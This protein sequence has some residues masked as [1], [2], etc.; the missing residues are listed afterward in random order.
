MNLK[1]AIEAIKLRVRVEDLLGC[2]HRDHEHVIPCQFPG[3]ADR[4]KPNLR[5]Y[6]D[7][8]SVYCWGCNTGADPIKL[9]QMLRGIARP[10][11]AIKDL[12]EAYHID[13]D[14]PTQ[15]EQERLDAQARRE[16]VLEIATAFYHR[17]LMDFPAAL[18]YLTKERGFTM[19]TIQSQRL[20]W[21][22][23]KLTAAIGGQ[24]EQLKERGL[25]LQ[26]FIDVGLVV[27]KDAKRYDFFFDRIMFPLISQH[28]VVGL[29]GRS[30]PNSGE[31]K[32]LNLKGPK[33]VK[34]G[35]DLELYNGDATRKG[36]VDVGEGLP[37]TV[38]LI[39]WGI[40]ATGA[41]GTGGVDN[42]A[43]RFKKCRKVRFPWDNDK[44]GQREAVKAASK[45][46]EA[47]EDGQCYIV[48]L[49]QEFN[50]KRVKDVNDFM[51]AGG[52]REDYE[53]LPERSLIQH[54]IELINPAAPA[55]ERKRELAP[56]YRLVVRLSPLEQDE[57]FD[58]MKAHLKVPKK[59]SE[60][61]VKKLQL[62]AER[63]PAQEKGEDDAPASKITFKSRRLIVPA[64]DFAF[65][66][67]ATGNVAVFLSTERTIVD[68]SGSR[69]VET[70]E[71]YLIRVVHEGDL[72]DISTH[73][74]NMMGLTREEAKRIP[75]PAIIS[76]R[77]RPEGRHPHAVERF[78]GKKIREVDAAKLF[79]DIEAVFRRY[80]WLPDPRDFKLLAAWVMMTYVYRLFDAIGYLQLHG[81]RESGKSQIMRLLELLCF[82][83]KKSSDA[84]GPAMFR[85]LEANCRTF[86][87]DEA[88]KLNNPQP[89]T[90]AMDLMLLCN[91][92]YKKGGG[93]ERVEKNAQGNMDTVFFDTYS[94]KVFASIAELNYVL[95]SRCIKIA[96][97]R[98]N[99]E[100]A[101]HLR[102]YAQNS[103]REA[104]VIEDIRD[105]LY[106]WM[107]LHFP[108]VH[109]I[110]SEGF[111]DEPGLAHLKGREREMWLPLLAIG[112]HVDQHRYGD[113]LFE[114]AQD[115]PDQ[116]LSFA[117]A[118]LQKVKEADR[119][120][121]ESESSL[122]LVIL[123]QL[124]ELVT[125][126]EL[127]PVRIDGSGDWYPFKETADLI[128]ERLKD[129]GMTWKE[130]PCTSRKLDSVLRKTQV[131]GEADK[132]KL[133][134]GSEQ[135]RC[136]LLRVEQLR[137]RILRNGGRLD[138]A[139]QAPVPVI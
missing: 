85:S 87:V 106:C 34:L 108:E 30:W 61:E 5:I 90:P 128:S 71:P 98:A 126:H 56:I 11:D 105:R 29:S 96:C 52:T 54:M 121:N 23:R 62:A 114:V 18:D 109:Y 35:A 38:T 75:S 127:Q 45:V 57:A 133:R 40:N 124:Y 27:E 36:V 77:W 123:T 110:Y 97:L 43:A 135:K 68:D 100:E 107:L 111:V 44:A 37:D 78:L 91:D 6:P 139:P 59:H 33:K 58:W 4:N 9:H 12:A 48:E 104:P 82:N 42:H 132:A 81:V 118:E 1:Q 138:E 89:G 32:Y 63:A 131:I 17:Q 113:R 102:D 66:S 70:L 117:L 14:P 10:I 26:D 69:K 120:A 20:G 94:P 51:L 95:A 46:Q 101:A 67:P 103:H 129:G 79:D 73:N 19:E 137:E 112:Q 3:H 76:G 119:R 92:G 99:H 21:A 125:T 55:A 15:E 16:A 136:F 80:I 122:E 53:A 50:G 31:M 93:A 25:S 72:V 86:F 83:A 41:P 65:N 24:A 47:L 116:I 84:S 39:Q 2:E 130:S 7:T 28:R 49:P 13:M 60:A 74:L 88:E 22:N 134:S 64:Q 115:H 8:N